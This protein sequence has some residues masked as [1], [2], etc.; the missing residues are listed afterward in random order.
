M[1]LKDWPALLSFVDMLWGT[2][3]SVLVSYI[4]FMAGKRLII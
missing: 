4:S 3:L 1:S 2:I